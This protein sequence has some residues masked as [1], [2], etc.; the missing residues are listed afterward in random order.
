MRRV[1]DIDRQ[2]EI[3]AAILE[4]S[5]TATEALKDCSLE[6][7]ETIQQLLEINK[8]RLSKNMHGEMPPGGYT[9]KEETIKFDANGQWKLDKAIKPGPTLD[10]KEMNRPK[11]SE[12][13]PKIDY[14]SGTPVYGGKPWKSSD[15]PGGK[16][17]SPK[18]EAKETRIRQAVKQGK[19]IDDR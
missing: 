2:S 6:E 19:V 11:Q 15:V 5:K 12:D 10:Y 9:F 18:M 7:V 16:I 14:T 13:G 3:M 17:S 1:M 4:K 8:H